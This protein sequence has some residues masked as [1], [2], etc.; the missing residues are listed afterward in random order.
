MGISEVAWVAVCRGAV[1][2]AR[3]KS[4]S[5]ETKPLMMVEQLAVSP[6]AFCSSNSTPFYPS[7][8]VSA[9]LKPWVAASSASC[10]TSWQMPTLYTVPVPAAEVSAV[11]VADAAEELSVPVDA[12]LP[13]AA[14]PNVMVTAI[15]KESAFFIFLPPDIPGI[16]LLFH[17][18]GSPSLRRFSALKY[19]TLHPSKAITLLHN[20]AQ[21]FSMYLCIL[22]TSYNNNSRKGNSFSLLFIKYQNRYFPFFAKVPKNVGGCWHGAMRLP[23]HSAPGG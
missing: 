14:R 5:E 13:H 12:E 22:P 21:T 18:S 1:A 11:S 9:S 8:S 4:T 16:P 2:L 7:F 17:G 3:I 15:N 23:K 19:S 6:E 20:I 10:C